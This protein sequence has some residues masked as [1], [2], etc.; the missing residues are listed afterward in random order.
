MNA[1]SLFSSLPRFLELPEDLLQVVQDVLCSG[2]ALGSALGRW[3]RLLHR[4]RHFIARYGRAPLAEPA[5]PGRPVNAH[6]TIGRRSSGSVCA[7][8]MA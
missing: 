2:E 8:S 1:Y 3:L 6:G 7:V 5:P 4:L